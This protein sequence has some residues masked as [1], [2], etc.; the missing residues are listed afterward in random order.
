MKYSLVI[1]FISVLLPKNQLFSQN[2]K[3]LENR[4]KKLQEEITLTNKLLDDIRQKEKNSIE[5]YNLKTEKIT[6]QSNYIN[7]IN[8]QISLIGKQI[9]INENSIDSLNLEL[10]NIRDEYAELIFIAYKNRYSV[11]PLMYILAAKTLNQA[12]KRIKYIQEYSQYRKTRAEKIGKL[13]SQIEIKSD[14]LKNDKEEKLN[15]LVDARNEKSTL[16][17]NLEEQK[18]L[19]NQ[20]RKKENDVRQDL[21]EKQ[22]IAN[23]L[24]KE[25][26][27]LVKAEM[28]KGSASTYYSRL[29]PGEKIISS[30]FSANMGKLPW[31]TEQ[32]VITGRFGRHPH[33]V[34]KGVIVNNHGIDI[35]TVKNA[36]VRCIFDGVVSRI[37]TIM[38]SSY[39]VIIRHGNYLSVYH[40]LAEVNV[41]Q[42][43]I[44]KMKQVIGRVKNE[45]NSNAAILHVELWKEQ[46]ILNPEKWLAN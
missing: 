37:L 14:E 44:V 6:L 1:L 33:P 29:T 23:R 2:R 38:G 41:K 11:N 36:E 9:L 46:E 21:H 3:E 31:P 25:I 19:M 4:K 24:E 27:S 30:N 20:L 32:G 5:E 7:E 13:I 34:V 39:T 22:K 12:Y 35:T 15:L 18:I 42:G 17:K 28:S 8:A 16:Q 43:Q 45:P 40:N 26:E 10:K